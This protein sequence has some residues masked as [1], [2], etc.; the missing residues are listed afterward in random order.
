MCN[1]VNGITS[2][3]VV[4]CQVVQRFFGVKSE[5]FMVIIDNDEYL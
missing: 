2:Q 4:G 1:Q 3:G 5:N